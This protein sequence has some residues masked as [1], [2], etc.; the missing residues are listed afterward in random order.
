VGLFGNTGIRKRIVR[1][2]EPLL[3]PGETL[4]AVV[5]A[6]DP[7]GRVASGTILGIVAPTVK[8][9]VLA[10]TDRRV[11]VLEGN[12]V[13][14]AKSTLLGA[15]ERERVSVQADL[16]TTSHDRV[17]LVFDGTGSTFEIP[18]LWRE[19]AAGMVRSLSGVR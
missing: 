3:S 7:A 10:L 1:A 17:T 18:R 13:N 16:A 9:F 11:L 5:Y 8:T 12:N 4:E 2:V 15:M 14:A 6:R 19:E